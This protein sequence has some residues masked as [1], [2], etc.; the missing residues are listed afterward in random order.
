MTTATTPRSDLR[1]RSRFAIPAALAAL[2][3][4]ALLGYGV[5]DGGNDRSID[6]A[7]ASGRRPPAPPVSLPGLGTGGGAYSLDDYRGKVVVLNFWASWCPPCRDEAP[8]LESWQQRLRA[9]GGTVVGVDVLDVTGDALLFAHSHGLT[10]PLVRDRDGSAARDFGVA[11]Y[12]E[13]VVIDR[14]GR[15]AAVKRGAV[16]ER[17]YA[18]T[19]APLLRERS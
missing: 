5:V 16:D 4:L 13:T 1:E 9:R 18:E 11:A 14:R 19:L 15:V 2:A 10:Y 17:F 8:V 12:P 7:V 3:L 6:R